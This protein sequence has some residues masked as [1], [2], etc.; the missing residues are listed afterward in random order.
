MHRLTNDE[1]LV[2]YIDE[3]YV[4]GGVYWVAAA[5]ISTEKCHSLQG[6]FRAIAQ[7]Y[8]SDGI[9]PHAEFHGYEIFHMSGHWQGFSGR[10][11]LAVSAFKQGFEA[12]VAS[13]PRFFILGVNQ[14]RLKARYGEF[15]FHPHEVALHNL[16]D[17]VNRYARTLDKKV[18][19]VADKVEDFE[20]REERMLAYQM[21]G[22][23]GHSP[24]KLTQIDFPI[25]W[26][27]SSSHPGLQ[28]VDMGL[29]FYQRRANVKAEKHSRA[30]DEMLRMK[31]LMLPLLEHRNIWNP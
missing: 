28:A 13:E 25:C 26:E 29:F 8:E 23:M 3:S 18:V 4:D 15:A 1:Y 19:L 27:D 2:A 10:P 5:I 12:V 6:A 30:E 7:R 22:T 21:N 24:S 20:R 16:L 17:R 11:A 31:E 14:K 9:P